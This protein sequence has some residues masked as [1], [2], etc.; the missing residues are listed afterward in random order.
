MCNFEWENYWEHHNNKGN[1]WTWYG[2]MQYII[3]LWSENKESEIGQLLFIL[4]TSGWLCPQTFCTAFIFRKLQN[5]K[6]VYP[7]WEKSVAYMRCKKVT[8]PIKYVQFSYQL[9]DQINMS[10]FHAKNSVTFNIFSHIVHIFGMYSRRTSSTIRLDCISLRNKVWL[11]DTKRDLSLQQTS[12][13]CSLTFHSR[14]E[15]NPCYFRV[16][17]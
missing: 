3:F 15:K 16:A 4:I 1:T 2:Y 17:W 14:V 11:K 9:L 10:I 6:E 7:Y 5:R 12:A 8:A 13:F